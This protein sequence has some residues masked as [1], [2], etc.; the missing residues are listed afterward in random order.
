M[1]HSAGPAW[2]RS[3]RSDSLIVTLFFL[4]VMIHLPSAR[5]TLTVGAPHSSRGS[6]WAN[7]MDWQVAA[8]IAI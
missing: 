5:E 2:T 4:P 7:D 1:I 6:R 3:A 8:I